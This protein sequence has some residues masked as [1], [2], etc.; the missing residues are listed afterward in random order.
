[1]RERVIGIGAGGHA[2]VLIEMLQL[3]GT[4]ELVGLLDSDPGVRGKLV[5]GV[6]VLGD[7]SMLSELRKNG[8]RHFFIGIG[9]VDNASP[10]KHLFEECLKLNMDP[11]S[12]IHPSAVVSASAE[13]GRGC[14]I[15]AGA[16]VG[17][18]VRLGDN[19]IVNT[20]AIVDHDCWIESHVHLATRATLSGGVH[21]ASGA[22]VGAGAVM[23]EL[24]NV[25]ENAVIGAGAAVINDVPASVVVAGV[26]AKIIRA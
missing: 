25:G 18:C 20:G 7:D 16:I 26:P 5:L 10:R 23:K 8:I 21:I 12:S 3:Q 22:H 24:I 9:S 1:M 2:K 13:I 15:M 17:T 6:P 4:F 11:I 14:M 19:V